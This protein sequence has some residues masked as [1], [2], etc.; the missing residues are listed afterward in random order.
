MTTTSDPS[1]LVEPTDPSPPAPADRPSTWASLRPLVLRLHFY[2][3]VLVAPFIL[4]AALTGIAY[5]FSPQLSDL[6]H[7]DLLIVDPVPAAPAQPLDTQVAAAL[8]GRPDATLSHVIVPGPPDRTTLVQLAA[9]GVPEDRD[10]SVHVDPYTAQV[11]GVEITAFDDPP[12]TVLLDQLHSNLLLG[13]V[14][15]LYSELAASWLAVLVLGGLALWIGRARARRKVARLVL[16]PVGMRPGRARI[17]GW[18][19]ATGLWLAGALLFIGA[20][21]MT[22][23]TYAGERFAAVVDAL[24]GRTPQLAAEPRPVPAGTPLITTGAALTAGRDAGLTGPLSVA[25]PAE[26]GGPYTVAER[27]RGWPVERDQVAVD[28]SSGAVIETIRWSDF[29]VPAKLTTIGILA[30]MGTLFG[31]PNQLALLAMALGLLSV[32]F[33]GYRMWWQ[34]RP[35]GPDGRGRFTEAARRG[36]L[37]TLDRPVVF[38]V[39]LVAVVVCWVAPVLGA[40]L[41]AFLVVDALLGLRARRRDR[42]AA[43]TGGAA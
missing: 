14:G 35:T 32:I 18:H 29:P 28:A 42:Q 26:P 16:P 27:G 33:W 22:W 1:V 21:G 41:V 17:R 2:A 38:V 23:S 4:V 30:H 3:G 13:D 36:R 10:L 8:S 37:R 39:V 6:V 12:L 19:G 5:L 31:L 25:A 7:R 20:T 43:V 34:R 11:R 24:H 40:S 9:P 15:R